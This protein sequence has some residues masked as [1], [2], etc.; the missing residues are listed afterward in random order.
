MAT[1]INR[2]GTSAVVHITTSNSIIVAGN[3]TT[4]N[5][6]SQDEVITGGAI[7]QIWWGAA[8]SGYWTVK[9]GTTPLLTLT[10]SG[11]KDFAGAGAS[12]IAN[13]SSTIN[14]TLVGTSDGYIMI[15]VQK[16]PQSTGYTQ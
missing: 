13:S 10:E 16:I 7:A 14:C 4:S 9:R 3:S 5:I 12:L 8:N 11:Y 1:I 6:A 15:E 2:S